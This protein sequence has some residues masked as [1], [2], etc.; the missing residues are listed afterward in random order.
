MVSVVKYASRESTLMG[1]LLTFLQI[2]TDTGRY[3]IRFGPR[4]AEPLDDVPQRPT[5]IRNLTL[6]ERSV[7]ILS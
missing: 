4:P 3:Y 7:S 2:F 6:E 5:I 1:L